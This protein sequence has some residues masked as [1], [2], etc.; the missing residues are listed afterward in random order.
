MS[1]LR[2]MAARLPLIR[3]SAQGGVPEL[4][5]EV[6]LASLPE[7]FAARL[8]S[9]YAREAQVGE[10]GAEY[11]LDGITQVSAD[12][13]LWLHQ[14]CL[15]VRPKKTLEIGLGYGFSTLYFLAAISQNKVGHHTAVD[16]YQSRWHGIGLANVVRVGMASSFRFIKD[17][18]FP[19]LVDLGRAGEE[20]DIIFIDGGH[21][22]DDVLV[23]FTLASK[24]CP[25][26]GY[27]V[28]DDLWMPSIRKAAAFLRTNRK[29]FLSVETRMKNIAVFQR[30]GPDTRLWDHFQDF[31]N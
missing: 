12:Q 9:M 5:L 16:P 19:A 23:D 17:L 31:I 21:K 8:A 20:F 22:F 25:K 14:L 2:K 24:L 7:V 28:L 13:G 27:I 3:R 29:D 4:D 15:K 11:L 30:V 26:D 6:A 10:A 18:S 1:V